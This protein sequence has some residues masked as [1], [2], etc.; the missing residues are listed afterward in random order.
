MKDKMLGFFGLLGFLFLVGWL[1][2]RDLEA[3]QWVAGVPCHAPES[4]REK[5]IVTLNH[6]DGHVVCSYHP[7]KTYGAAP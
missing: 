5:L 2:N 3:K 4:A 7:N 6:A 1:Q